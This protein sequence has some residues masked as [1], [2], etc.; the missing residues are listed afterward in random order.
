MIPDFSFALL[1]VAQSLVNCVS[2]S[3]SFRMLDSINWSIG[4]T[5][6]TVTYVSPDRISVRDD[7]GERA[8]LID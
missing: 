2:S 5:A 6:E 4:R 3:F 1:E 7:R 8:L